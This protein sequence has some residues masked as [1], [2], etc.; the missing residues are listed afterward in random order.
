MRNTFI[1]LLAVAAGLLAGCK[2]GGIKP[3]GSGTIECTQVQVSPQVAGRLLSLVPHE[4]DVVKKGDVVARIDASDHTL[5]RDE[6]RAT[7]AQA[8]AQLD[9][10][11]AGSRVEDVQRAREQVREAKAAA[12]AA[13]AD[14]RRIEKVF[15]QK[16]ATQKQM[17]DAKAMAERSSAVAAAAVQNLTR[18]QAGNRPE[19]IQVARTQVDTAKAKLATLEKAIADCTVT[20]PMDGVVTTRS[21]EDGE[22]AGVGTPL[23]T[24]S[25]LDEV[26]LSVYVPETRLGG[27][28]L[29]QPAKVK[30]DGESK[31]FDGTVTF[32]SPEAEFTPKNVQTPDERA[33]LVYRLKIT[34]PNPDRV[35]K[36][37]MPADGCLGIAK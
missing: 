34:L 37:G 6:A 13:T 23:I 2:P 11:L 20:A 1:L 33:K 24:L 26:W 4:G 12:D 25:R 19:E 15:E 14:L 36:P 18:I 9:L 30:L 22:M 5:R 28:K 32:I 3:D 21:R 27:V 17:D 8:Q 31:L 16:S 10:M 29:G 35:F 7:V